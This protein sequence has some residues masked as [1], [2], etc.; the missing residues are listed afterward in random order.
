[1]TT[2]VDTNVVIALWDTDPQLNAAAQQALDALQAQGALV[3]TGAIYAELLALPGRTEPMLDEFLSVTGMRADWQMS[4]E[5][6]RLAG[7]AFQGYASRRSTKRTEL[8]RR[9]LADFLIGAHASVRRCRLLTLDQRL[10]R[11]AFPDLEVATF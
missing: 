8:P 9:I 10:Y 7:R 4:E 2:I 11:A 6:W 5:I 3:I 1:M